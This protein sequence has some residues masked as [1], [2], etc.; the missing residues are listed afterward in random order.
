M[1]DDEPISPEQ[2]KFTETISKAM[3]KELAPLIANR[4]QTRTRSTIYKGT[5][6]GSIDGLLPLM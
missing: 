2:L 6:D 4:E 1:E 3:F 5:K